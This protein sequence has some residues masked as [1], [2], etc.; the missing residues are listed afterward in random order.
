MMQTMRNLAHSWVFKGLMLL[1]VVSFGIWGI[2]DM[3]RGNALKRGVAKT[4]DVTIT[5]SQ[6]DHEFQQ[7][8]ARARQSF[9]P[10]L[11]A[12][13]AEALGLM[14]AA[15]NG[16]VER[17]QVDQL[18][19][20]LGITVSD[21]AVLDEMARQ[22][23]FLGKNGKLDKDLINR[24]LGQAH[25]SET[26]FLNQQKEN[27]AR[28]VLID[29]FA[30][31]MP[32]PQIVSDT[33]YK[34]RGQRMTFDIV[35][36]RNDSVTDIPPATDEKLR[37]YY[38]E[39]PKDFTAPEYRTITM[40]T[41]SSAEIAKDITISD[42]DLQKEY[43]AKSEEFARPER[44]DVQQVLL[45]NEDKAKALAESAK[46]SG[47]LV[48]AAKAMGYE[49]IMLKQSDEASML[50]ELA[51]PVFALGDRQISEPIK[52]SLGWHVLQIEKIYPAGKP[53]FAD[54]KEDLREAMRRDQAGD[55]VAKLVNQLDDD[56]AAG[57]NLDDIADG[58]K[59]RMIKIPALDAFG[60][61]AEGKDPAEL[62]NKKQVLD[63]A[64]AQG[65]GE[66]SAVMDGKQGNYFV[67]R[68]E[69]ITPSAMRPFDSVKVK[70]ADAWKAQEQ[71]NKAKA[72]AAEIVAALKEGKTAE[73]FNG[74]PGIEIRESKPISLLGDADTSLPT[75]NLPDMLKLKKG[76]AASYPQGDKQFIVRLAKLEDAPADNSDAKTKVAGDLNNRLP[77]EKTEQ[78]LHY[79]NSVY[80]VTIHRDVM[81]ELAQRG[82]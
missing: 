62:P 39:H 70:V 21:R 78:F 11:N 77:R 28:H 19:D 10:D 3:F 53:S 17:A 63:T 44:R 47:N 68:T 5:V 34:T 22:P 1:L 81:D 51:K 57:H 67:V 16:L 71:A 75:L 49:A 52:S 7:T 18:I 74:Q 33:I 14:D 37:D 79:L 13:Q 54:V 9:G 23:Q 65:S 35:T 32:V 55:K 6:L 25:M 72:H 43:D 66:N 15:L 76:D 42:E 56:L 36:L 24:L 30:V 2:G 48:G 59:L 31:Q 46:T 38:D 40:A 58:M 80:P 8:L 82:I 12:K 73:S 61:T 20:K 69:Q 27:I 29:A 26:E 50:P 60:K 41:L 64:F 4:G 45:Q